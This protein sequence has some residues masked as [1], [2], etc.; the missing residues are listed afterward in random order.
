MSYAKIL[1]MTD[2]E[3][4][5]DIEKIVKQALH[6]AEAMFDEVNFPDILSNGGMATIW[7]LSVCHLFKEIKAKDSQLLFDVMSVIYD[8][9]Y[10]A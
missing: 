5:E 7:G 2:E 9:I 10:D 1:D 6:I 3:R 4:S 8:N